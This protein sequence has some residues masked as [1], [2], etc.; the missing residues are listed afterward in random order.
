MPIPLGILAVAGAGGGG[1]VPAYDL[2]ETT[3]LSSNASSIT[4]SSLGSYSD[5]KHLQ[6]RM[7]ARAN[8]AAISTRDC[9][10]RFNGDTSAIYTYHT[11]LGNGSS[12]DIQ[13][14]VNGTS[15]N[16]RTLV[17]LT[18]TT[19][20][21]WGAAIIDILDFSSTNKNTTLRALHGVHTVNSLTRVNL[22]SG[23]WASTAAIT[24]IELRLVTYQFIAG[25]RISLY[26]VK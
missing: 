2:L 8:D 14:A 20:D 24:S 17:P 12:T 18:G 25:T 1:G 19:A 5:Y 11:V 22:T 13:S 4:F 26:G 21:S 6:L 3:V 16:L 23:L 15:A 9:L 7:V 10:I